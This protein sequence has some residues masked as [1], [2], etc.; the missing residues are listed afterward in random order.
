MCDY[1]TV[2]FV[3]LSEFLLSKVVHREHVGFGIIASD[4]FYTHLSIGK[5]DDGRVVLFVYKHKAEISCHWNGF[6]SFQGVMRARKNG[7]SSIDHN[8][9]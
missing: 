4:A 7:V 9:V 3:E 5:F 1:A 6:Q 8:A 2:E